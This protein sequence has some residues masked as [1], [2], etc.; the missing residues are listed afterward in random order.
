MKA[1]LQVDRIPQS[2]LVRSIRGKQG[3]SNTCEI[4]PP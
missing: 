3:G 2:R 1:I 4:D